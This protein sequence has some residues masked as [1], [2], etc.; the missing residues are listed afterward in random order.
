M[1]A[2]MRADGITCR[3]RYIPVLTAG[4]G[5]ME[6]SVGGPHTDVVDV[7]ATVVTAT[8]GYENHLAL[9]SGPELQNDFVEQ[10]KWWRHV[11]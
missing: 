7:E 9:L 3:S 10:G 1:R 6:R 11:H 8:R 2:S 5:G 4:H